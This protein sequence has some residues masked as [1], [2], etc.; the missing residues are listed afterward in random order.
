MTQEQLIDKMIADILESF[1][2]EKVHKTMVTLD[3]KWDIGHGEMAV[4]SIYRMMKDA[5]SH[6][7]NVAQYYGKKE[8]YLTGSGGFVATLESDSITLQ[9]ILTEISAYKD[10][11]KKENYGKAD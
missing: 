10:D 7:R 11:Y 1:D 8:F 6:L 2:F 5:E 4:P 3:W 9:F